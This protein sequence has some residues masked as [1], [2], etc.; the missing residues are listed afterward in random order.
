MYIHNVG[1]CLLVF[2]QRRPETFDEVS[3]MKTD[4][5]QTTKNTLQIYLMCLR[6]L[7]VQQVVQF[8]LAFERIFVKFVKYGQHK[9]DKFKGYINNKAQVWRYSKSDF[10][11]LQFN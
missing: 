6:G 10:F 7:D 2:E 11:L 3:V 4:R 9:F 8:L 5:I 1:K